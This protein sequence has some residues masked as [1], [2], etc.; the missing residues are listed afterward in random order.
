MTD[1][2]ASSG[3]ILNLQRLST[4]DG[5]GLRT[6]VFFKGCPLHCQWCHNPESIAP[7]Q[8][9]QW[10]GARCI[11][12]DSCVDVCPQ[13]ALT[14]TA[15]GILRDRSLCTTCGACVEA[16]PSGAME[17]LGSCTSVAD[18]VTE[19]GKDRAY[20]EKSAGGVTLSGGEPTL[21]AHFTLELAQQLKANGLNL[22]LDTCA[23]C[24]PDTL[25]AL[26]PLV[27]IFLV[28]LKL[29]DSA[30]HRRWTGAPLE[31]ILANLRWLAEQVRLD[32]E[33]KQLWIRTPLIPGATFTAA[34]LRGISA[35]LAAELSGDVSRWELCAFN[36]LCRDKYARLEMQW[37]FQSTDLMSKADLETAAIW[38]HSGGFDPQRT[39]VTGAAKFEN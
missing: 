9:V 39:F 34:N 11:G 1:S 21:Q 33:H 37:P 20:F 14:H 22:A 13:Q 23:L 8:Q 30:E 25:V 38:A 36:N 32:L 19:L 2:A 28:D 10:L 31:P 17:L 12:C 4:E 18:L 6:T 16:C 26:F 15:A 3:L 27:D 24:R 5:P 7:V 29:I 35:F